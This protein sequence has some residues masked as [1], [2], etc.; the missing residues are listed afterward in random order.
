MSVMLVA[1]CTTPY[2]V[3]FYTE[4]RKNSSNTWEDDSNSTNADDSQP[5]ITCSKLT[6]KTVEQGVKCVQS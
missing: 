6:I 3:I 5:A 2:F 4:S 1:L